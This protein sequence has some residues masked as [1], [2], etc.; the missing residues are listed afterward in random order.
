MDRIM[1]QHPDGKQGV[2]IDKAKYDQ[3][4]DAIKSALTDGEISFANLTTTVGESLGETFDGSIG[5]YVT[6]VKLDL[7][8]RGIIER[9]PDVSPQHLRLVSTTH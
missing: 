5:W 4:A 2:N 7:E 8:A 3:V 6:T 9:L 1:T